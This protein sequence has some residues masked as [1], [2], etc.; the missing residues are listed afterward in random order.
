MVTKNAEIYGFHTVRYGNGDDNT[1]G[2]ITRGIEHLTIN[3]A[4]EIT[5]LQCSCGTLPSLVFLMYSGNLM[6]LSIIITEN[7]NSES[8]GTQVV[9]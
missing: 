5:V 9:E 4:E 2:S 8:Y 3:C 1:L 7:D 6:F